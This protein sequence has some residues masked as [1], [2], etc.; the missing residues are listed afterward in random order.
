MA[1]PIRIWWNY[2]TSNVRTRDSEGDYLNYGLLSMISRFTPSGVGISYILSIPLSPSTNHSRQFRSRAQ[3]H[4]RPQYHKLPTR[5]HADTPTAFQQSNLR[6]TMRSAT[7]LLL[8]TTLAFGLAAPYPYK[9]HCYE[10]Y[11]QGD[12][13]HC[14]WCNEGYQ[15]IYNGFCDTVNSCC[16]VQCCI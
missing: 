3:S 9:S 6:T 10:L 5:S 12:P 1:I 7:I 14:S 11:N 15:P 2:L 4:N 8:V 13:K 16:H